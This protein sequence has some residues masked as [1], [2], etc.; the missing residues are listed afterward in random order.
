MLHDE[1]FQVE[2][3]PK[4][5]LVQAA[6]FLAARETDT[7]SRSGGHSL[8][9]NSALAHRRFGDTAERTYRIDSHDVVLRHHEHGA[10]SVLIDGEAFSTGTV[11]ADLISPTEIIT[12]LPTTRSVST[13]IPVGHKLHVFSFG[14]HYQLSLA[15][16]T[17][18]A[19]HTASSGSSSSDNLISPMP[20][21]VLEVRVKEGDEVK[22]GQVCAVLESMKMEINIRAGRDG[23]IDVVGVEKGVVVEE[24]QVLVRLRKAD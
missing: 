2:P 19:D 11:K 20:A 10:T 14:R 16:S 6:L 8:W 7:A 18:E 17:I 1:L 3:L 5:V 12:H 24:G 4:E 15:P 22:E 9:S 13:M 21:R 23:V